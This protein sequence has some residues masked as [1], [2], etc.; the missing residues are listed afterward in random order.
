MSRQQSADQLSL[1]IGVSNRF[2]ATAF[3]PTKF[4]S[5]EDKAKFANQ[6]V[7]FV[8][9]DCPES[10]FHR[11]FYQ[12]LC[13]MFRH[14]AHFN[15]NG[16]YEEWFSSAEKRRQFLEQAL[17]SPTYGDPK[18]TWSDVERALQCWTQSSGIFE[19]FEREA[20]KEN[21][22]E[23]CKRE[24]LTHR[25]LQTARHSTNFPLQ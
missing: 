14:I 12:R 19:R 4:S 23:P 21:S 15:A 3:T 25:S 18:W 10:K 7:A 24:Q 9:A 22:E 11:W 8:S 5:A 13:Q 16:F 6:F 20:Q 17:S 2:S 1:G